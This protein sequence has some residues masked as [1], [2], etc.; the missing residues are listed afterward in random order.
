M[1]NTEQ[2]FR[3]SATANSA[4]SLEI[5]CPW[6]GIWKRM[7]NVMNLIWVELCRC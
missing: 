6:A 1:L 5:S 4:D 7:T 2:L 3:A